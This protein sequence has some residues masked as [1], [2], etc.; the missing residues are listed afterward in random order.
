MKI[1]IYSDSF[2]KNACFSLV[3]HIYVQNFEYLCG[4]L[5][6]WGFCFPYNKGN[7]RYDTERRNTGTRTD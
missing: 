2:V 5:L 1:R 6:D 7:R 3:M 4:K